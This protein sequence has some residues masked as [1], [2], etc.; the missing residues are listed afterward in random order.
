[1][2]GAGT[3]AEAVPL[4][5]DTGP[6]VVVMDIRMPGMDD[7]EATQLISATNR[8][9]PSRDVRPTS[10]VSARGHIHE[11]AVM[12]LERDGHHRRR[13]VPVLGNDEVSLPGPRRLRLVGILPV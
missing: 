13:P 5:R 3:G 12:A 8:E 2:A 4:V 9:I 1:M 6:D 10:G 11:A 7:I